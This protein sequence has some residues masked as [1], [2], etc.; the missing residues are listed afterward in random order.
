MTS[1]VINIDFLPA[2][3][4]GLMDKGVESAKI[5]G[6]NLYCSKKTK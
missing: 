6:W 4:A 2:F 5:G 3:D 1:D